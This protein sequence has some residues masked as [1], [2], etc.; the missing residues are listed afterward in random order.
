M[1]VCINVSHVLCLC[2]I[3][4]K[5]SGI[6]QKLEEINVKE[7]KNKYKLIGS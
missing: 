5:Y 4:M 1:A 3:F 7:R 6:F 2:D